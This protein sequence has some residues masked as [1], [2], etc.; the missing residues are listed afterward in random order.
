MVKAA[1]SCLMNYAW[2]PPPQAWFSLTGAYVSPC[3]THV[4][5]S[6]STAIPSHVLNT[7]PRGL[8]HK[9][10]ARDRAGSKVLQQRGE[11]KARTGPGNNYWQYSDNGPRSRHR[12]RE[13]RSWTKISTITG[14]GANRRQTYFSSGINPLLTITNWLHMFLQ[15]YNYLTKVCG[16]SGIFILRD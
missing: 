4:I 7:D 16:R 13:A 15:Y 3:I 12:Q 1:Y 10:R 9:W 11:V 14:R 2:P 6:P 5:S 8:T